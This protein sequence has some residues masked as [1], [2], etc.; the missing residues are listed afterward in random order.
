MKNNGVFGV[1]YNLGFLG[2]LVYF[3]K[4]ATSF[5]VGNSRYFRSHLVNFSLNFTAAW[6]S[7]FWS[8]WPKS[9]LTTTGFHNSFLVLII[10][11]NFHRRFCWLVER[12]RRQLPLP[13]QSWVDKKK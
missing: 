10:L 9:I 13:S 11:T 4:P 12:G 6:K 5:W 3:L 2:A 7:N 1:I 8:V